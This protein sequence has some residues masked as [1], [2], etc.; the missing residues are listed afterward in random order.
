MCACCTYCILIDICYYWQML[1]WKVNPQKLPSYTKS[2]HI[3]FDSVFD[4]NEDI[5]LGL[6][7]GTCSRLGGY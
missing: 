4:P 5:Q 1:R 2:C 7:K 3:K 6:G